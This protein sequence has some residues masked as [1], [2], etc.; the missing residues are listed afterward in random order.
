MTTRTYWARETTA[1]LHLLGGACST[2][3][4]MGGGEGRGVSC[5][6]PHAHSLLAKLREICVCFLFGFALATVSDVNKLKKNKSK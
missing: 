5:A 6:C 3:A 2:W 4:P 1:T